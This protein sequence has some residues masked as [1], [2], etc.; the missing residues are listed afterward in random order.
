MAFEKKKGVKHCKCI[1]LQWLSLLVNQIQIDFNRI[2]DSIPAV[3]FTRRDKS[4]SKSR[5][6]FEYNFE[7]DRK[8]VELVENWSNLNIKRP[9]I[10]KLGSNSINFRY[11][12]TVFD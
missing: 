12:S 7:F 8:L 6:G 10:G 5:S 9:K 1:S 2:F 4:D 3:R 11:K